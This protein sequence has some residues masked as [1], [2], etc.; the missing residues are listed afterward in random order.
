MNYE[1]LIKKQIREELQK[2]DNL[3]SIIQ[4]IGQIK[5]KVA[6][7]PCS[8]YCRQILK[9]ILG[10]APDMAEKIFGCFDK[11]ASATTEPGINVYPLE[12][13]NNFLDD[14]SLMVIASSTYYGRQLKDIQSETRYSGPMIKTSYFDYSMPKDF[15][16]DDVI[17]G[18]EQV[19][20]LLADAKSKMVYLTT[21]LS[22]TLNDEGLTSLFES[23][24]CIPQQ[25]GDQLTF[26]K[27]KI[28]GINDSELKN[29]LYADVYKMKH[30]FPQRGDCI[31]DIGAFRG[32]TAIVFADQIESCGKI[33][34]FEPIKGS[35]EIMKKNIAENKLEEVI[36]PVNMGCSDRA[37]QTLAVSVDSGAPWNFIS[38]D[39]GTISVNL[40][41]IDDFA[42]KN[43][44]QKIDFIKMDVEGFEC[45]AIKGGEQVIRRDRPRMA[46]A[47]YHTSNDLFTI[48]KL[49]K[50]LQKDYELYVRCNMA[51][52]Y[53]LTLFCR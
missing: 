5:G 50:E 11:S 3:E 20:S 10:A 36:H 17:A 28:N 53:G 38:E 34:A 26:G 31:L 43:K 14:I 12:S 35:F 25:I 37:R 13:L 41:T 48:P 19:T 52:P 42:A 7:Y 49:V 40:T 2:K 30:V 44:I 23:E 4:K 1:T 16:I 6:F 45:D 18:I 39:D 15:S 47:L 22:R 21:W 29:E 9:E 51:G 46:I 8:K 33:Y 24:N 32:E 27:Y